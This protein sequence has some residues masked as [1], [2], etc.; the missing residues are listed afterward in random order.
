[1]NLHYQWIIIPLLSALI[2]WFTNWLAVKMLFSP[3]KAITVLGFTF[4]GV[5]PK[6][7]GDIAKIIG[8]TIEEELLTRGDLQNALKKVDLSET[9]KPLL[10]EKINNLIDQKITSI[11]P[12]LM[13]FL[14]KE[15]LAKIKASILD[16]ILNA[17]PELM[18][19]LGDSFINK[20]P[21]SELVVNNINK[22]DLERL[23][24]MIVETSDKEFKFIEYLGGV[25]G[26]IIGVI[27][28]IIVELIK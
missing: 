27:Q 7:R 1:L 14:P 23:E 13:T 15:M 12:M 6:R 16:E 18:E 21:I 2:G 24:K 4:Q 28:V 17:L 10:Q 9:V 25:V 26:F 5:I 11:S 22:F 3:R 19:K 20:L 8:K